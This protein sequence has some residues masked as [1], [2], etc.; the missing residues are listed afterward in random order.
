M[1]VNETTR[2]NNGQEKQ[3]C[4]KS[5][6]GKQIVFLIR[7][8]IQVMQDGFLLSEQDS[9]FVLK[10][11]RKIKDE[12]LTDVRSC[13]RFVEK[14]FWKRNINSC[15]QSWLRLDKFLQGLKKLLYQK[16]TVTRI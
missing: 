10:Y 13:R 11:K 15:G 5:M 6:Q 8:S 12:N 3:L 9:N 4:M 14:E 2:N 16:H 1:Y 7:K